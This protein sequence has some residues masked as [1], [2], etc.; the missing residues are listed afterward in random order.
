LPTPVSPY[1]STVVSRPATER[2]S[3]NTARIGALS[4]TMLRSVKRSWLRRMVAR[5]AAFSSLSSIERRT[6][7]SASAASKGFTR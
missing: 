3:S 7:M 4:A 6:T 1:S 2:I 5:L